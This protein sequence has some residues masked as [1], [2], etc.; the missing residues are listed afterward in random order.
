M[1]LYLPKQSS[2]LVSSITKSLDFFLESRILASESSVIFQHQEN[3]REAMYYAPVKPV[4]TGMR[5]DKVVRGEYLNMRILLLKPK[6][7]NLG[8]TALYFDIPEFRILYYPEIDHSEITS[9][10][11]E[12]S[13]NFLMWRNERL[14][15]IG[16]QEE[17]LCDMMMTNQLKLCVNS[18]TRPFCQALCT[19]LKFLYVMTS[20]LPRDQNAFMA[21]RRCCGSRA[22]FMM[23]MLCFAEYSHLGAA[24]ECFRGNN[25][26][27]GMFTAFVRLDPAICKFMDSMLAIDYENPVEYFA[28]QL[29]KFDI[30]ELSSLTIFVLRCLWVE[31]ERV[32]PDSQAKYFGI[33]CLLFLRIMSAKLCGDG[34]LLKHPDVKN[35]L[36]SIFNLKSGHEAVS[37]VK[38]FIEALINR[39]IGTVEILSPDEESLDFML[40]KFTEKLKQ[41]SESLSTFDSVFEEFSRADHHVCK[42]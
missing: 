31:G 5:Q 1:S 23:Q 17:S 24:T 37:A 22:M 14:R 7:K 2:V 6:S 32:F 13:E 4:F 28:T 9:G 11:V 41:F 30:T 27:T 36:T 25:F 18:H 12:I 26:F 3:Q 16:G 42:L 10:N 39:D 40:S 15:I 34:D 19:D 33:S 20:I 8:P 35:E 38:E 21:W 29:K